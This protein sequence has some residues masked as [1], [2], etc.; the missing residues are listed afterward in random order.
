MHYIIQQKSTIVMMMMMMMG[1]REPPGEY[2]T[3][4]DNQI[5]ENMKK[6]KIV[7]FKFNKMSLYINTL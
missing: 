4:V 5:I 6:N 2:L 7:N 3:F 1:T